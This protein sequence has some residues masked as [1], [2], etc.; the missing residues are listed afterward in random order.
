MKALICEHCG[1]RFIPR[2]SSQKYCTE[3]SCRRSR[4]RQWQRHKLATDSDYRLAQRE[5]QACWLAKN[6][7]YYRT[8]RRNHPSYTRT[9]RLKQRIRNHRHRRKVAKMDAKKPVITGFYVLS[10]VNPDGALIAK[11]DT[12]YVQLTE[13]QPDAVSSP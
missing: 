10:A 5:A 3:L 2:R 8:Y 9:N 12:R 1:T 11:M 13:F 4:K 7:D 6:P